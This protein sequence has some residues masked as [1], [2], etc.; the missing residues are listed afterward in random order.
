MSTHVVHHASR[1]VSAHH[2]PRVAQ[3]HHPTR[4]AQH[5]HAPRSPPRVAHH[6]HP[7]V[8]SHAPVERAVLSPKDS[9]RTHDRSVSTLCNCL[10]GGHF[11]SASLDEQSLL[12]LL[13][14]M[15][16]DL[17]IFA[18]PDPPAGVTTPSQPHQHKAYAVEAAFRQRVLSSALR[19]PHAEVAS[20]FYM[21]VYPCASARVR[22]G[23]RVGVRIGMRGRG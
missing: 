5:R 19:T 18:Y 21:P 10:K 23:V 16:Q 2:P 12:H 20:L 7:A 6:H 15:R 1:T 13:T 11:S 22:V 4:L 17:R 3:P 14:V 8:H 9:L